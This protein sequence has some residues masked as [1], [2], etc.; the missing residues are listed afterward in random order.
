MKP[1][2]IL[3]SLLAC[4]MGIHWSS[5]FETPGEAWEAC[6]RGDWMIWYL[7]NLPRPDVRRLVACAVDC[8]TILYPD[9]EY[10]PLVVA[11]QEW[12]QGARNEKLV[13]DL[14]LSD[15]MIFPLA[16]ACLGDVNGMLHTIIAPYDDRRPLDKVA[17]RAMADAVRLRFPKPPVPR[18]FYEK[19]EV[20]VL[21]QA[22]SEEVGSLLP[23]RKG[24]VFRLPLGEQCVDQH[25][26]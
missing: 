4:P 5:S 19:A 6:E 15:G 3:K 25:N 7:E 9:Y 16:D 20:K 14:A 22:P 10:D 2:S 8:L 13:S 18:S 23:Q 17:A 1:E 26:A 24:V 12:A 11:C 21:V